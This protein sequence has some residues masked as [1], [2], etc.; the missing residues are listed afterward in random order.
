MLVWDEEREKA[1][2]KLKN[3]GVKMHILLDSALP[4]D[5]LVTI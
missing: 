4:T 3:S 5:S 2:D 1:V